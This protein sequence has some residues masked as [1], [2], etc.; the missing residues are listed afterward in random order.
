[1]ATIKLTRNYLLLAFTVIILAA[2]ASSQNPY[3]IESWNCTPGYPTC[4]DNS[5]PTFSPVGEVTIS[6][7]CYNS[8]ELYQS[9][10]LT[11]KKSCTNE[12]ISELD[13][14]LSSFLSYEDEGGCEIPIE[15]GEV[16][17]TGRVS[18]AYSPY[19]QFYNGSGSS[20]CEG[21]VSDP[22]PW[23]TGC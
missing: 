2:Q 21:G 14:S 18:M 4:Q 16:L 9:F 12:V 6:A 17:V 7:T 5:G 8:S 15:V 22:P 13:A 19:T 3:A 10:L 20:D 23:E 11:T 1:M